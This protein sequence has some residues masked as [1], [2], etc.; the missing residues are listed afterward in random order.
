MRK[1]LFLILIA[2]F[3]VGCK[4]NVDIPTSTQTENRDSEPTKS[5]PKL[6]VVNNKTNNH[7]IFLVELPEY[8]I[9]PLEI[10]KGE[11]MTFELNKGLLCYEN[12]TVRLRYGLNRQSC[13][14]YYTRVNFTD[15]MITTV[16][17]E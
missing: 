11:S 9:S 15:G 12:V 6:K 10:R 13:N 17:L 2:L 5:Y 14:D 16:T 3:F 4:A 8:T 1:Y 7:C